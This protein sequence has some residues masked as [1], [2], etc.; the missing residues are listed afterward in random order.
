MAARSNTQSNLAAYIAL[1][2]SMALVGTSMT[3]NKFIV[4]KV[5]V[6]LAGEIR[7][8]IACA[9]AIVMVLLIEGRLPT[10]DRRTHI[11]LFLQSF[12][13]TVLFNT[14]VLYG[15]DMTTAAAGGIILA[16]TPAVIAIMSWALGD[17]LS[18]F[19]WVGILL[20][21]GGILVVNLM[22]VQEGDDARR[23]IL[24]AVFIF[25]AVICE[26]LY[27]LIGRSIAGRGS[28]LGNTAWYCIYGA[29]TFLPLTVGDVRHTNFAAIPASAWIALLY[30][31]LAVTI[32]AILLW[33]MGLRTVPASQA[34]AFTGAM[35]ITAVLSAW[36]LLGELIQ[37]P[38]II[39]MTL[40]MIGIVMV[41]RSRALMV[42]RAR[43]RLRR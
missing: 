14:L 1:T 25:A 26:S 19:A 42:E 37:L 27:T 10:L 43:L 16:S 13:G 23:P 6:L 24:G 22:G 31:G 4:G 39:G 30:M 29:L 34:G 28:P 41:A 33:Y 3:A 18:R 2:I 21:I 5:P 32:V 9:G 38:H 17:R 40:I 7:M 15:V 35:P 36:L 8:L 12:V 11:T 20:T